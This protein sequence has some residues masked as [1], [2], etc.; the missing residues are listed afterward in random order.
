[1]QAVYLNEN[2]YQQLND[3]YLHLGFIF[4]NHATLVA[5]FSQNLAAK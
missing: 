3:N 5:I 4:L 1:M 2:H